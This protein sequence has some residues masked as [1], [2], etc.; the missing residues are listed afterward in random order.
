MKK[1]SDYSFDPPIIHIT[2]PLKF[3]LYGRMVIAT[4]QL[5]MNYFYYL[6]VIYYLPIR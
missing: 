5:R 4:I 3:I 1:V 2:F 6:L